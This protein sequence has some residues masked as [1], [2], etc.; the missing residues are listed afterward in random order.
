MKANQ[1]FYKVATMCRVLEVSTSGYYTW[2]KRPLSA[3]AQADVALTERI[4]KIHKCSDGTYGVPRIYEELV[5]EG[6]RIGR[7]RVARLMRAAGLEGVSRRK[8]HR[9]TYRDRDGRVAADLVNRDFTANGPDQL[10][11]ADITYISTWAGFLYLAVVV[12]AWSRRVVGWAMATHLRAELVLEALNMALWQRQPEAVIH[13]SD[14]GCQY[15]SIAFGLRCRKA[16][17][18]PSMRSTGDCYDNALCE[19]FFATLECERLDR[20]NYRTQ[21]EARMSVFQYIEGWYNSHRRHSALG[22]LSPMNF[23]QTSSAVAH[24]AE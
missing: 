19:S 11:V 3:R 16:G 17:V 9:T 18:R 14:Q 5:A 1:A 10:W 13:H 2:L 4:V 21:A 12:D 7:K 24:E 20:R 6:E 22:Y 23:E 8:R 15:T